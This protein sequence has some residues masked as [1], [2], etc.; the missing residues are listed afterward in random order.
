MY[1]GWF[2][3]LFRIFSTRADLAYAPTE[4]TVKGPEATKIAEMMI[5]GSDD[6]GTHAQGI[7]KIS[8]LQKPK[9]KH[10]TCVIK[11]STDSK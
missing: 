9:E 4:V 8:C 1:S 10:F 11:K 3:F 5:V 7:A 6:K 2:F